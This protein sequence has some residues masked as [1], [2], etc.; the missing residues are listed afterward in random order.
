MPG[1]TK[2]TGQDGSDKLHILHS[3]WMKEEPAGQGA[4]V[5]ILELTGLPGSLLSRLRCSGGT[6]TKLTAQLAMMLSWFRLPPNGLSARVCGARFHGLVLVRAY[7]L[8]GRVLARVL[9][10][11]WKIAN[12]QEAV[13]PHRSV[14]QLGVLQDVSNPVL[15]KQ[16]YQP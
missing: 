14:G 4:L 15:G 5:T 12:T 9:A 6:G 2:C 11:A 8:R 10:C 7:A 3:W 1:F 16:W 13:V